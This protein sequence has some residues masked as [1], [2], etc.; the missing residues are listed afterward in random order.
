MPASTTGSGERRRSPYYGWLIVALSFLNQGLGYTVWYSF[1][2]FYVALLAEFGWN[3]GATS[4]PFS[5]FVLMHSLAGPL[6]G[7]LV[8][9]YGPRR[10]IP[11]GAAILALGVAAC[12]YVHELWQ[13]LLAYGLVGGIGIA[14]I[15][16]VPNNAVVSRW[17]FRRIGFAAGLAS[18]GVG[19]GIFGLIPAMD[20]VITERDWQS[21]YL[22]L[23][24]LLVVG[25]IPANLIF[26]RSSPTEIGL[27]IDEGD[28]R[29]SKH[30][31]SYVEVVVDLAWASR[32]WTLGL[33]AKT[34]R[35]W[36]VFAGITLATFGQQLVM[37]HQVAFLVDAGQPAATAAMATSLLGMFAVPAKILL[38]YIG[39]RY[40]RE[41]GFTIGFLANVAAVPALVL[42]GQRTGLDVV[43][44]GQSLGPGYLWLYSLLAG[45][46]FA[47][48]GPI[49]P[50]ITSDLFRGP[51]FGMIFGAVTVSAGLGAGLGAWVGGLSYDL[52]FDY[53]PAFT[54]GVIAMLVA[55]A[56]CWAAAPRHVRKQ[57]RILV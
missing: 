52:T 41:I 48:L 49:M 5:V 8:D 46:G 17:F 3:R 27:G 32:E 1:P 57:A 20:R 15:G 31:T 34:S 54:I 35:F 45:V 25:L 10:V 55:I 51:S 16:W 9:R 18:T 2:V 12:A 13:L 56:C 4:L 7:G 42:A 14:S 53:Q 30:R 36:L 26:M 40:G 19:L 22:L 23:A 43:V 50:A 37:V 11:V 29:G 33:A 21:A 39:D 28:E 47:A 44:G 6:F 38:G 24:G